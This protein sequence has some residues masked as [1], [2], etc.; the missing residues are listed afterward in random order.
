M[1]TGVSFWAEPA[2][3]TFRSD[4]GDVCGEEMDTV[5]VEVAPRAVVVLGGS[6]VD[7]P[8]E[9]LGVAERDSDVEGVGEGGVPH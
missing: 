7:V 6:R 1:K 8:G 5:P 9:D 4:A 2:W 3:S